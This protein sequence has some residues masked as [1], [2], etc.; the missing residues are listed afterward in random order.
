MASWFIPN[1]TF[2][3]LV[4]LRVNL[5]LVLVF[6]FLDQTYLRVIV[7]EFSRNHTVHKIGGGA[8][9]ATLDRGLLTLPVGFNPSFLL[10]AFPVSSP[11]SHHLT[12]PPQLRHVPRF[13]LTSCEGYLYP[14]FN[15]RTAPF[16]PL[17][18]LVPK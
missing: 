17:D 4:R 8:C 11:F 13:Q 10:G 2:S 14:H 18:F 5:V 9:L 15:V 6:F 1:F 3:G 16:A 12:L 7:G